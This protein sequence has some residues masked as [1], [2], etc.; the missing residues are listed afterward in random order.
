M[1]FM[2]P[3]A[4]GWLFA[5]GRVVL[6]LGLLASSGVAA[7]W[8]MTSGPGVSHRGAL[9]PATPA[10]REA[11]AR[12]RADVE[13]LAGR[14]GP[15]DVEHPQALRAAAEHVATALTAAGYPVRR[16]PYRA[17]G[18]EVENIEATKRGAARPEEIVVVGAHYDSAP[19]T[20]GADDNAS[21]TAV[22]L[23]VARRLA[24]RP[25]P[26]TVRF[27]GFVNE[28]PPFFKQPDMG[29]LVYAQASRAA[30]ERVVA[31]L[32][33]EM[34]G[35]YDP[36]PGAQRYPP[37]LGAAYP[38]TGDFVAFVGDFGAR[39]LVHAAVALFRQHA[40]FPSEALAGPAFVQGVD[41]S[42]HWSFRQVGYPA[43]MVTDTAF[44]RNPHY[45]EPSDTPATLDYDRMARVTLGLVEVVAGLASAE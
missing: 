3:D 15:R 20:P 38:D 25:L 21:G 19:T 1:R 44:Y 37:P 23:E 7:V 33:L 5:T 39:G 41:F 30:G 27:V 4:R 35:Y 24:E 13:V 22:M 18:Q 45:H 2:P 32:S 10:E 26:R 42:D 12:L 8:W 31:M 9:P 17:G 11:A 34:L 43:I 14:I 28:E 40:R 6:I 16:Q 29:S 36:T